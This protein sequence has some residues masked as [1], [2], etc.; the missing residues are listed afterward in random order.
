M[1][2]IDTRRG[3]YKG[4]RICIEQDLVALLDACQAKLSTVYRYC[5]WAT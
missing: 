5:C 1:R 3:G 2:L 4:N